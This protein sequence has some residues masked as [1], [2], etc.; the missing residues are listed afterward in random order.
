M[1]CYSSSWCGSWYCFHCHGFLVR[2]IISVEYSSEPKQCSPFGATFENA[3]LNSNG[4]LSDFPQG[5]VDQ[6]WG[7]FGWIPSWKFV[8]EKQFSNVIPPATSACD[9]INGTMANSLVEKCVKTKYFLRKSA[10]TQSTFR[11]HFESVLS[12]VSGAQ[13]CCACHF[14]N[15]WAWHRTVEFYLVAQKRNH[16]F[17]RSN[18]SWASERIQLERP[19]NR[20]YWHLN[21]HHQRQHS[22]IP[23]LSQ[24]RCLNRLWRL[25][26]VRAKQN[27]REKKPYWWNPN[28]PDDIPL[29]RNDNKTLSATDSFRFVHQ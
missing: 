1:R 10:W 19:I 15:R 29:G 12:A 18:G 8:G 20:P 25:K 28:R 21:R 13:K 14:A 5:L 22:T 4:G 23:I 7:L 11:I 24:S 2:L 6:R 27:E 16:R 26:M 3:W 17:F 9:A